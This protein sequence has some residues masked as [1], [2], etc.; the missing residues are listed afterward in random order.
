MA[1][2]ALYSLFL[3]L[4]VTRKILH[5]SMVILLIGTLVIETGLNTAV[6]SV[7]TVGRN[8]YW[9][10]TNEYSQLVSMIN[11]NWPFYRVE[12]F[13]RR[14]KND[15]AWIGYNSTSVF[16]STAHAGISEFFKNFG[17]EGNTNAYCFTG[18]T[19]LAA[20]ML[21][22]K[23]QLSNEEQQDS[24]L[25][26]KLGSIDRY[27]LYQNTYTLPLGFMLPEDIDTAWVLTKTIPAD[28][29]NSFTPAISGLN[30][31]REI[32]GTAA[33]NTF[34]F[35]PTSR[36]M[37]FVHIDTSTVTK[38]TA[39]YNGKTKTFNDNV[40]NTTKNYRELGTV[41]PIMVLGRIG[42]CF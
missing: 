2:I 18:A 34:T 39:T 3:Y 16:S 10:T 38:V 1:F 11:D 40:T 28:S 19:P 17:F 12:K 27:G 23:Y 13:N 33:C 36:Q 7:N 37:I 9:S 21:S 30:V 14:T 24:I 31:L 4:D 22:V 41:H 26:R 5:S 32:E 29:Q 8:D 20:S 6:T 42:F 35:T 25:R 15:A